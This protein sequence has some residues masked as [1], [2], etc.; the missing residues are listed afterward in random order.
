MTIHPFSSRSPLFAVS[1]A[2]FLLLAACSSFE[3]EP[4]YQDK[5]REEMYKDGSVVS[6]KGGIN[7][8]GGEESS[9]SNNGSGIGVNAFLWRASLDTV[10]FMPL[11][12]ADP[13][14]GVIITDWYS[15]GD[16]KNERSKLNIVIRDRD[17]RADGVKVSVFRQTKDSKGNW[18]DAPASAGTATSIEDAIL[19]KA[20]QLRIA[21]RDQK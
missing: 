10:S 14:G 13:F 2:G 5:A 4:T 11:A 19:T 6:D 12:S 18:V 7:L 17:L 1:L 16:N 15:S 9:K 20:R 8:F 21:Q 3:T